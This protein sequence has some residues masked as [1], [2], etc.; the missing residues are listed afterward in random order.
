MT[1]N[2][3]I[4]DSLDKAVIDSLDHAVREFVAVR[5]YRDGQFSHG[6]LAK[7]LGVGRGQVDEILRRYGPFDEFT[8]EEIAAQ[9]QALRQARRTSL[10]R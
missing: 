7:F 1:L 9:V 8:P 5:L 4:P 3:P 2:I 6:K 10:R